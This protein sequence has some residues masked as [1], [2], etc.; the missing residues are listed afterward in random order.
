MPGSVLIT[1]QPWERPA[2]STTGLGAFFFS[3][4]LMFNFSANNLVVISQKTAD[5][6]IRFT[7]LDRHT[8]RTYLLYDFK[9]V[10]H[11]EPATPYVVTGKVNAA[12][13]Q[14]FL[15]LETAKRDHK[16]S[17]SPATAGAV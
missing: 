11:F 17:T 1:R 2:N 8:K 3:S 7:M 16:N 13:N 10:H 5:T 9:K 6:F 12:N 14:L 4:T 15:V